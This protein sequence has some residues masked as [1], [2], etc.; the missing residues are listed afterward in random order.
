MNTLAAIP[1]IDKL[2]HSP[3]IAAYIEQLSRPVV[4]EIVRQQVN[5][6]RQTLLSAG[7]SYVAAELLAHI[8]RAL[9]QT[10]RQRLQPVIN[11]TGIMIHT[12]LGRAPLSLEL[13]QQAGEQVCRYSNLELDLHSGKRGQR[14]GLLPQLLRALCSADDSLL[15]NNNA[16]ALHLT[17]SALAAGKEVLVS[18]GEQ[19]QIG[20]GFR[21]PDIIRCAGAILRD[22]GTTNVTTVDDYLQAITPDT[23]LVLLVHPSNFHITGFTHSPDIAQLA[24]ALP[25]HV[26]LV[27]DQGSGNQENWLPG[28]HTVAHYL[29]NG[30]DLV[31]FSSDKMLSSVQGGIISG[32]RDLIQTLAQH[33][34]MRVVRP[35]KVTYALLEAQLIQRLNHQDPAQK[36]LAEM[37]SQ[38]SEWHYQRAQALLA[39]L[40]EP[41][42]VESAHCMVGG[43]T[44]PRKSFATW[45]LALPA[46]RSANRWLTL[47]REA[48]TPV[49]AVTHQEQARIFPVSVLD[50]EMA[51]LAEILSQILQDNP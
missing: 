8:E 24:A 19:I 41:L 50:S 44:T 30:A 34:L 42:A 15:V 51:Q 12:N 33:P 37:A 9:H 39:A 18:R 49:I 23:A 20:G 2:L 32:R 29:H 35:G 11:A 3:R 5:T 17:I 14:M 4:L 47:L 25:P 27:V 48:K 26:H 6:Y 38:P 40:S 13:W 21:I 46:R 1:Q 22:V 31:C 45:A 43:G 28:E 7:E 36:R 16:A 10:Q